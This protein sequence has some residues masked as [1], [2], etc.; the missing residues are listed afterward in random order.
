MT[1]QPQLEEG[2]SS[3]R[4]ASKSQ[5]WMF[6]SSVPLDLVRP[7]SARPG[8]TGDFGAVPYAPGLYQTAALQG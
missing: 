1:S 2:I 6:Q 4:V 3:T 8:A 5:L 7:A